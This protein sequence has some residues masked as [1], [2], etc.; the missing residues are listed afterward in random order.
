MHTL[1]DPD[2]S[3]AKLR[4]FAKTQDYLKDP[5]MSPEEFTD[6]YTNNARVAFSWT[7][8]KVSSGGWFPFGIEDL[9]AVHTA[10][11]GNLQHNAGAYDPEKV[12]LYEASRD[13]AIKGME[14]G[15][16][17]GD[18]REPSLF[19][20]ASHSHRPYVLAQHIA[21]M[22]KIGLFDD[23]NSTLTRFVGVAYMGQVYG[24]HQLPAIPNDQYQQAVMKASQDSPVPHEKTAFLQP[25]V[26]LM[27]R[28]IERGKPVSGVPEIGADYTTDQSQEA[29]Q[30]Q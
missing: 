14:K 11:Y 6:T 10:L 28:A 9:A 21:E 8:D 23:H 29:S 30:S 26:D 7:V 5:N 4:N 18:G 12:A 20:A 1:S 15:F 3:L 25:M 24:F 16:D 2:K 27:K 19:D 22:E 17:F 13:K